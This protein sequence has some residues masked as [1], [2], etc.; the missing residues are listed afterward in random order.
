LRS[1]Q[2]RAYGRRAEGPRTA[3]NAAWQFVAA[4][5]P[6]GQPEVLT[7][8]HLPDLIDRIVDRISER[9]AAMKAPDITV[10]VP[11]S[12]PPNVTVQAPNF[13][14]TTP[15]VHVNVEPAN[16]TVN[17]PAAKKTTQNIL[18]DDKGR[19]TAIETTENHGT[20]PETDEPGS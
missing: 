5:E 10:N 18:R 19:M 15:D 8:Q 3:E 11:Q 17:I 9:Q 12:P 20:Q 2:S 7:P 14:V 13:N 16:L 4:F 1:A 6:I